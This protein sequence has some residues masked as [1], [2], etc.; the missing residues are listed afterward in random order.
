MSPVEL[1]SEDATMAM[2]TECPDIAGS[3]VIAPSSEHGSTMRTLVAVY[4]RYR[5]LQ[6][7]ALRTEHPVHG[8]ADPKL[9][10]LAV[11]P[12]AG[13]L[14]AVGDANHSFPLASISKVVTLALVLEECGDEVLLEKIGVD[15]TGRPFGSIEA[16]EAH[17]GRKLNPMVSPGAIATTGSVRGAD[18]DEVWQKIFKAHC[19]FVGRRLEVNETVYEAS[20]QTSQRLRAIATLM[21]DYGSFE[22]DPTGTIDVYCRQCAIVATTCDLAVLGATIASG[23][24]NPI[25]GKQVIRSEVAA[26]LLA[27]MATAGLYEAS[28]RWLFQTGLPAKSGVAGGF[29]AVAPGKLGI[30]GFSPL[31]DDEGNSVRSQY[32]IRDACERLQANPYA[33]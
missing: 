19:D 25:S 5:D 10:G 32:A 1:D 33:I 8:T 12:V 27:V 4:E 26:K 21:A 14:S 11:M 22:R 6:A 17:R 7:G 13:S 18:L 9:F 20:R 15:A 30:A 2:E 29:L 31:L 3:D 16:V 24:R 28:G 23:G